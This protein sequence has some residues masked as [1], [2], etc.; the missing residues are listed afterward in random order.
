MANTNPCPRCCSKAV[1][2]TET[3]EDSKVRL[4]GP[5]DDVSDMETYVIDMLVI[6][7]IVFIGMILRIVV[8]I[9][10]Q[11]LKGASMGDKGFIHVQ[12]RQLASN[13]AQPTPNAQRDTQSI[14]I[15]MNDDDEHSQNNESSGVASHTTLLLRSPP[16][17][18]PEF[19]NLC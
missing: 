2:S 12:P 4:G 14:G 7:S 11:D 17:P 8:R 1:V 5:S 13:T 6:G 10:N 9:Q 15:H 16:S 3:V 19:A 18:A